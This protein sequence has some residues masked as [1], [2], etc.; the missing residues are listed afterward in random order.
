VTR[1]KFSFLAGVSLIL[2]GAGVLMVLEWRGRQPVDPEDA[3]AIAEQ[4]IEISQALQET[5]DADIVEQALSG[6]QERLASPM[7]QAL[8][9]A[10]LE[11]E[12]FH[13]NH[14]DDTSRANR[15]K[16]CGNYR[17]YIETGKLPEK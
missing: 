3:A 7:G 4:S 13:S 8:S 16:A 2:G 14:P 10:C 5:L 17:E 6:K 9:R 1:Q 15:D 12:E 11:W